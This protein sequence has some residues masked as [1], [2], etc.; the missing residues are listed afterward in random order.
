MHMSSR[1]KTSNENKLLVGDV[2]VIKEDKITPRSSWRT[3]RV[4]S[5]ISGRDGKVRGAKLRTIPQEGNRTS[6]TRPLQ[7]LIPLEV[8]RSD[9][10]N[11]RRAKVD[12]PVIVQTDDIANSSDRNSNNSRPKRKAATEGEEKRRLCRK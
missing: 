11:E 6:C 7:K 9:S 5:L 8:V 10:S 1:N 12:P 2:V 4:E 3:G